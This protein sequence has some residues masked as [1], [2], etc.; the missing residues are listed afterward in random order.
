LADPTF[1][2]GT[3]YLESIIVFDLRVALVDRGSESRSATTFRTSYSAVM[4]ESKQLVVNHGFLPSVSSER[5]DGAFMHREERES[6][7]R[8]R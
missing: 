8:F 6:A 4:N 1:P 5:V 3:W 2:S 7:R